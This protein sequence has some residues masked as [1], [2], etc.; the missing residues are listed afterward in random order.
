MKIEHNKKP[1]VYDRCAEQFGVD[2]EDGVI[3]TYGDTIFCKN[4]VHP[5]KVAH[6]KVHIKQQGDD[7][8][9]WWDRY[10]EDPQFRLEQE[11]EAYKAET[12]WMNQNM[13]DRNERFRAI[14]QNAKDISSSV[15]GSIIS[16]D[17]ALKILRKP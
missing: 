11:L 12:R 3:F 7:P 2:W 16:F 6:E 15:Y 9:A 13:R 8:D 4:K 5:C 1:P 10:F 17:E 14:R